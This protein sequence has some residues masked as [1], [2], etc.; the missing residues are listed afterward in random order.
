MDGTIRMNG[1]KPAGTEFRIFSETTSG[2]RTILVVDDDPLVR[3]L[4]VEALK[5]T[6]DFI[7]SEAADG[8]EALDILRSNL[9]DLVITDIHM[10]GM[11]GMDLLNR[12]R[13]INPVIPVIM[14]TGYPTV[15]LSVSAMKTGAVDF[16]SKPFHLDELLYKV[17]IYLREK[18]LLTAD[19]LL[20]K[21]EHEKLRDKVRQVSTR[22]F[23][24]DFI[25]RLGVSNDNIFR[26]IAD[27]ALQVSNGEH[28]TILLYDRET[29][30][31]VPK[32]SSSND[33][34]PDQPAPPLPKQLL[35][36]VVRKKDGVLFNSS[37]PQSLSSILCTPLMIRGNVFGILGLRKTRNGA[38]F[39]DQDL[40]VIESLSKRASLNLENKVLYETLYTNIAETFRALVASI[41]ARDQYTERH[42]ESVTRFV[43]R[44]AELMQ[45]SPDDIECLRIAAMLHDIG[46]IAIPDYILLKPRELT[47]EEYCIIKSHSTIGDNILTPIALFEKERT[48]IR[49]HHEYWNGSGY[50]DGLAG[51]SIPLLSRLIAVA[52][53]YD[54]M[55]T[56][57]PYRLCMSHNE[58]ISEL[59]RNGGVQFDPQVVNAFI[60]S[61]QNAPN[62]DFPAP[63]YPLGIE[64]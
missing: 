47:G 49:H 34:I 13:E 58:A 29:G 56:N 5:R 15:D 27:L 20:Q 50:P 64:A 1:T 28:C 37:D 44:T 30:D 43:L 54:A 53:A 39:S 42:S 3:T 24:Y 46:K 31:F 26:V 14:I 33:L 40:Y 36:E 8:Q 4:V 17:N 60:Q 19:D 35:Q 63:V 21:A 9:F 55:T 61:F 48:V 38:C 16:L 51:E 25:E 41:Q 23:I 32:I 52:D 2:K 18:S 11:N 10:P 45:C 6:G 62:T 22:G 57:R 7:A 12:I 59:C